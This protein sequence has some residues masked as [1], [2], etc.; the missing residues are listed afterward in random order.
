M[1]K[2][3][4]LILALLVIGLPLASALDFTAIVKADKTKLDATK[5]AK[6]KNM[7]SK[8]LTDHMYTTVFK[9]DITITNFMV[10][11]SMYVFIIEVIT[12]DPITK[13]PYTM[14]YTVIVPSRLVN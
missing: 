9:A 14:T 8:E 10:F 2:T 13:K 3:T 6:M 5:D 11:G 12:K 7:F 1:N 4:Y